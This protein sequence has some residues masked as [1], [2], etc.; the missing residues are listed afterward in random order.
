MAECVVAAVYLAAGAGPGTAVKK[1]S[2]N[3][4]VVAGKSWMDVRTAAEGMVVPL[5]NFVPAVA[6]V[7]TGV[8]YFDM[9]VASYLDSHVEETAAC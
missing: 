6:V 7:G 1:A 2:G 9:D 8:D 5:E 3:L 4:A